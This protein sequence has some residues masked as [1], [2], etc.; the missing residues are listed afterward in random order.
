MANGDHPNLFDSLSVV[1]LHPV[2][3]V[4]AALLIWAM[5]FAYYAGSFKAEVSAMRV[6]IQRMEERLTRI[7]EFLRGRNQPAA[8]N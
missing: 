1:I 2:G 7:D 6:D 8:K 5:S 3:Q 4:I